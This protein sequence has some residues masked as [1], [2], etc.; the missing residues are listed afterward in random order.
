M[1][2]GPCLVSSESFV[3]SHDGGANARAD[4]FGCPRLLVLTW[5]IWVWLWA[6]CVGSMQKFLGMMITDNIVVPRCS[7]PSCWML[8]SC[9]TR[10]VGVLIRQPWNILGGNMST[11]VGIKLSPRPPFWAWKS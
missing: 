3:H 7:S 1:P 8:S 9:C 2:G 6:I 11:Y 4:G 5:R 10:N